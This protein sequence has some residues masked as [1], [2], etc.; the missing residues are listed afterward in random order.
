MKPP[1]DEVSQVN[2]SPSSLPT[3][4]LEDIAKHNKPVSEARVHYKIRADYQT[5]TMHG[6][7]WTIRSMM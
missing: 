5:R 6:L 3:Y 7:S 1:V 2:T 4:S